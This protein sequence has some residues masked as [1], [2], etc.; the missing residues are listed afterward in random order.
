MRPPGFLKA[1]TRMFE[2]LPGSAERAGVRLS[3]QENAMI[4]GGNAARLLNMEYSQTVQPALQA[5]N[6]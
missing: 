3:P 5:R 6:A 4:M 1:V 2:R